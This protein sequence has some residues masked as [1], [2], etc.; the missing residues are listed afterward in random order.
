MKKNPPNSTTPEFTIPQFNM[1][2]EP[3]LVDP[4]LPS[5]KLFGVVVML[6]GVYHY[7]RAIQQFAMDSYS[8]RASMQMISQTRHKHRYGKW[9]IYFDDFLLN[10]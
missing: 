9:T 6:I 1:D 3:T 5:A 4:R 10:K 8:T 7:P 2:S